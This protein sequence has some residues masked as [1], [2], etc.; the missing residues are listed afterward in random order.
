[1]KEGTQLNTIRETIGY[2][3]AYLFMVGNELLRIFKFPSMIK[4]VFIITSIKKILKRS[5]FYRWSVNE[6]GPAPDHTGGVQ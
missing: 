4:R 6:V 1:M 5:Y 3:H 2:K